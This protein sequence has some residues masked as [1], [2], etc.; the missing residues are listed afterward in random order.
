MSQELHA[1]ANCNKPWAAERARYALQ[2]AEAYQTGQVSPDEYKAL[3]ED[4]VRTDTLNA[5][6]DDVELK[7]MLVYAVYGLA[8][9]A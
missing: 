1:I 6:A 5:E 2:L 8:K 9:I 4:L 7:T 3:L